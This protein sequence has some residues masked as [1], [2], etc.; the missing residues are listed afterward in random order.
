MS[1]EAVQEISQSEAIRILREIDRAQFMGIVAKTFP[2]KSGEYKDRVHKV[3]R[4]TVIVGFR[5]QNSVNNQLEKLGLPADFQP[6]PRS[7]GQHIEG[8]P[9]VS[10]KGLTYLEVQT[11]S[12]LDAK[13][14][15]DGIE[16]PPDEIPGLKIKEDELV[17]I[18]DY[19][20]DSIKEF[21]LGGVRYRVK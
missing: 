17:M 13:Y 16:T 18:R 10:H 4:G 9:L 19:Q 14:Y 20:M 11:N 12:R 8:T 2:V 3:A 6:K 15:L 7:W 21:R 5:Y 1:T